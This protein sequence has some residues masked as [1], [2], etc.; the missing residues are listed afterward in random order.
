MLHAG[1]KHR[2]AQKRPRGV[3]QYFLDVSLEAISIHAGLF[4]QLLHR[5]VLSHIHLCAGLFTSKVNQHLSLTTMTIHVASLSQGICIQVD[6]HPK[7]MAGVVVGLHPH[8]LQPSNHRVRTGPSKKSFHVATE[9]LA[10]TCCDKTEISCLVS[11]SWLMVNHDVCLV[12]TWAFPELAVV[13]REL[14]GLCRVRQTKVAVLF[15]ACDGPGYRVKQIQTVL[16]R[17]KR[18]GE[19]RAMPFD[20][21]LVTRAQT[22]GSSP[23]GSVLDVLP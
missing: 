22:C 9:L 14:C 13:G 19:R 12:L 4:V 17:R 11:V 18:S 16:P 2:S 21:F 6:D 23:R 5:W 10:T 7:A 15:V 8:A 20:F 3:L 1:L